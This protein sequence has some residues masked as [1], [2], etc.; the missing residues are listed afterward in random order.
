MEPSLT[1][2]QAAA[3][4]ASAAAAVFVATAVLRFPGAQSLEFCHYGEIG[5]RIVAGEGPVTGV[6]YPAEAALL[7]VGGETFGAAVAPL[8]RFPLFAFLT[9]A[10]EA[11]LGDTDA[12]V[13]TAAG[14]A[15]AGAAAAAAWTL[16]PL[17][18]PSGALAASLMFAWSP[19]V[20]RGFALWG[21]PD[22]SF[23]ALLLLFHEA[24]LERG[25]PWRTGLLAG[26]CWLARP[27]FV[28]FLPVYAWELWRGP[29]V[30]K[31]RWAARTAGAAFLV[32]APWAA[33]Q[34][35]AGGPLLNPNFLWNLATGVLTPEPAW[36]YVRIFSLSDFGPEHAVPLALKAL[37]GLGGWLSAWPTLWQLGPALP[38]A[39][40]GFVMARSKDSSRLLG[41]NL[42]LLALQA[43]AFSLLRVER[44]GEHV[45][46]RYEL[47]FAPAYAA[48]VVLGARALAARFPLPRWAPTVALACLA[49]WYGRYYALPELGFGHP[50]GLPAAWP[51]LARLDASGDP[52]FVA[53]NIPAHVGWYARRRAVLL[54]AGPEEFDRLRRLLPIGPIL[55]STLV[56]G[57]VADM[58]YWL[59]LLRHRDEADRFCARF[60]YRIAFVNPQALL[61]LPSPGP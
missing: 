46:G 5:R 44:L 38:L 40:L 11:L 61:L 25:K 41:L 49:G 47:W 60:G 26:L 58:P 54:P 17:L 7:A 24:W 23:C 19:S 35:L 32:A 31:R 1:R 56:I 20:V 50:A 21:Y 3:L 34:K 22:L 42:G 52:S 53:T 59:S 57:Q 36:R 43:A 10:C 6:L 51:E 12:A 9:G 29:G 45:A 15:L 28:L 13:L 16:F 27:N 4:A 39:V 30:G 33:R 55:L 14:L 2:A 37:S 48:A 8:G 18:G